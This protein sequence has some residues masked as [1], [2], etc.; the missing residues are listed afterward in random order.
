MILPRAR[1][2]RHGKPS[3]HPDAE[4]VLKVSRGTVYSCYGSAFIQEIGSR[5][6]PDSSMSQRWQ[7]YVFSCARDV[8]GSDMLMLVALY[9]V[10]LTKRTSRGDLGHLSQFL[11]FGVHAMVARY[12]TVPSWSGKSLAA[13]Q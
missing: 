12:I 8:Y 6:E 9:R 11:D 3:C 2:P 5:F 13:I 7:M 4:V 1:P 10:N